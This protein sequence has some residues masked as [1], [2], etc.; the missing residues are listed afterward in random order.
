MCHL[1]LSS[2]TSL[3]PN[4]TL[5]APSWS[6]QSPNQGLIPS[7][8]S[9]SSSKSCGICIPTWS[10]PKQPCALPF[11]HPA[12]P[13]SICSFATEERGLGIPPSST[14]RMGMR[15]SSKHIRCIRKVHPASCGPP[16]TGG[17]PCRLALGCRVGDMALPICIACRSE[18]D[19]VQCPL[20]HKCGGVD[21]FSIQLWCRWGCDL[22]ETLATDLQP[23]PWRSPDKLLQIGK[24]KLVLLASNGKKKTYIDKPGYWLHRYSSRNFRRFPLDNSVWMSGLGQPRSWFGSMHPAS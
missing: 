7:D 11:S 21:R 1:L 20:Q 16:L 14:S 22:H 13:R 18:W 8:T 19:R 23:N 12:N 6:P 10:C 5:P 17:I 3:L 2:L 4:F 9:G 15:S 24:S